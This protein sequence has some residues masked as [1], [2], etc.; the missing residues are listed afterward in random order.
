[1]VTFF[2]Q[3]IVIELAFLGSSYYQT[4]IKWCKYNL[5]LLYN[6]KNKSVGKNVYETTS[7]IIFDTNNESWD[8][9]YS[10][11]RIRLERPS[12]KE[13]L[14]VKDMIEKQLANK[15][16][17]NILYHLDESQLSHYS[18]NEI[19]KIYSHN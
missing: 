6:H 12:A 2:R 3:P 16:H 4:S 14:E 13:I 17:G 10:G 19:N 1:M 5:F 9:V 7:E 18:N 8:R 11:Y 15:P